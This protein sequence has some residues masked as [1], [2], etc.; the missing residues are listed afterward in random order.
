MAA[1][2]AGALVEQFKSGFILTFALTLFM[3]LLLF[4]RKNK[5]ILPPCYSGWIP[6]LGCAI[7]FGKAPLHFIDESKQKVGWSDV[8][9][10]QRE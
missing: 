7:E 5:C 9:C 4:F 10:W 6:W 8:I 1:D 2:V 3:L